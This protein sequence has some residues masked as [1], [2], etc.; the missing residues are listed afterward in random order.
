MSDVKN[1]MDIVDRPCRNELFS[2]G[3]IDEF[4]YWK[5]IFPGWAPANRISVKSGH[6]RPCNLIDIGNN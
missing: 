4:L 3:V 2:L 5:N 1:E 6:A